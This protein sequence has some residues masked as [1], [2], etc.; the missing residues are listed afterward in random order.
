MLTWDTF[1][2]STWNVGNVEKEH[3]CYNQAMLWSQDRRMSTFRPWDSGLRSKSRPMPSRRTL[4]HDGIIT[5]PKLRKLS[6][7]PISSITHYNSISIAFPQSLWEMIRGQINVTRS[8]LFG[9]LGNRQVVVRPRHRTLLP[10]GWLLGS[11]SQNV[12]INATM[13]TWMGFW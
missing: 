2:R 3:N 8:S 5:S 4:A 9:M 11:Q 7:P 12:K 10:V 1:F 13:T 6:T